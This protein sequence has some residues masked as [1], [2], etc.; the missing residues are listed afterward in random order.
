MTPEQQRELWLKRMLP[1]LGILIVYFVIISGFVTGKTKKAETEYNTLKA[2]VDINVLNTK[3]KEQSDLKTEVNK[4]TDEEKGVR[5][6]L[7][8]HSSFLAGK[9]SQNDSLDKLSIIF[10][11]HSLQVLDEK[12]LDKVDANTLSK[13]FVDMQKTLNQ[14]MSAPVEDAPATPPPAKSTT[15]AKPAPVTPT[16][17]VTPA[18]STSTSNTALNLWTIHYLGT[19]NDSYQALSALF[20]RGI[21]VFPVSLTMHV[22]TNN[23]DSGSMLEW[24]LILWLQ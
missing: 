10:V 21:K 18:S 9:D 11:E 8:A 1:A 23:H 13:S 5:D 12:K 22:P 20:E 14:L 17:P 4:L 7:I 6:N 2:K 3:Q 15:S 24:N 19:Y 16:A